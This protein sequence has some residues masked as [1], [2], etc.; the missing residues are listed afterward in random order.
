MSILQAFPPAKVVFAGVGVLL[1]VSRSVFSRVQALEMLNALR[2]LKML[3]RA[4]TSSSISAD[5][6]KVSSSGSRF[7]PV[8]R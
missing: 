2:Q 1:L 5:A 6:L 7:I 3:P 8:S 4:K